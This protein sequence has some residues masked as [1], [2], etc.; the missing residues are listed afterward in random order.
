MGNQESPRQQEAGSTIINLSIVLEENN[1]ILSEAYLVHKVE[2]YK[3]VNRISMASIWFFDGDITTEHFPLMESNSIQPGTAINIQLCY[4]QDGEKEIVFRGIVGRIET[5]LQSNGAPLLIAHCMDQTVKL[6]LKKQ[7]RSFH[8]MSHSDL[9]GEIIEAYSGIQLGALSLTDVAKHSSV[10]QYG[11]NDWQ[12]L[13]SRAKAEGGLVIVDDNTISVAKPGADQDTDTALSIK[14]G[15]DVIAHQLSISAVSGFSDVTAQSW[16]VADQLLREEHSETNEFP[17]QGISEQQWMDFYTSFD[18]KAEQRL[19][20][21]IDLDTEH[22][23][24]WASGKSR[25]YALRRVKGEILVPGIAKAKLNT[26]VE[27]LRLGPY[28]NGHGYVSGVEHQ[29]KNGQWTTRLYLGLDLSDLR[30]A[31]TAADGLYTSAYGLRIGKVRQ[32]HNDPAGDDRILIDIQGVEGEGVWARL[33]KDYA[34]AKGGTAFIPELDDEVILGFLNN[35]PQSPIILGALQSQV[36]NLPLTIK[37]ENFIKGWMLKSKLQLLFDE[38]KKEI[39]LGTAA[40]NQ[41]ILSDDKGGILLRDQHGNEFQMNEDGL[42]LY[43]RSALQQVADQDVDIQSKGKI[44][45]SAKGNLVQE[46]M[47]VTIQAKA[48]LEQKANIMET[49]GAAQVVI[50]GGIVRIN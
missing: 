34:T 16:S 40:G 38:E 35:D 10:V 41:I 15:E 12:L 46:G 49:K 7:F 24:A 43:S 31:S 1:T 26:W 19:L 32:L 29:V 3:R 44:A 6:T 39:V 20:S 45:V 25:E 50:K 13:L 36:N 28:Y 30:Q 17:R 21:H 23:Q 5:R 8:E 47:N 33:A 2:V 27:L 48:K 4:G 42:R 18:D 11:E 22:L 37:E 14:L 9:F